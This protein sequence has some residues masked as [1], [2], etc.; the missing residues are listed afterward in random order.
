M[1]IAPTTR[2]AESIVRLFRRPGSVAVSNATLQDR[3]A[4]TA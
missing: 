4:D 2:K 1:T 3:S